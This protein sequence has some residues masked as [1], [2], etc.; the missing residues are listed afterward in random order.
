[1]DLNQPRHLDLKKDQGLTIEWGDGRRS[2]YPIEYLRKMSPA[3][4]AR[5]LRDQIAKNPLTVLPTGMRSGPI[6]AETAELVGNYAIKITFTDGHTSP[7]YSFAYLRKIDPDRP[8]GAV[9]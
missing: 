6:A 1:M 7:I 5:H 2:F 9:V 8:D 4:D 3:A